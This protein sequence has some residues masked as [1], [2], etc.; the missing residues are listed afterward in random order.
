MVTF[1]DDNALDSGGFCG[2]RQLL[3]ACGYCSS[4]RWAICMLFVR[5]SGC[6][7]E[8]YS[9][10]VLCAKHC[11]S[12]SYTTLLE[13]VGSE[14]GR[15]QR[16]SACGCCIRLV[17]CMLCARRSGCDAEYYSD[18]V[19]MRVQFMSK[20]GA[21]KLFEFKVRW[22]ICRDSTQRYTN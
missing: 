9:D 7:A 17:I 13:D 5:R 16:L 2:M 14:S 8:F 10:L 20:S 15:R 19:L 18:L 12:V 22:A 3:S 4:V 6:D 11:S 1:R 21:L